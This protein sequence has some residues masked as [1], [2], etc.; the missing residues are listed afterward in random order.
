MGMESLC[1]APMTARTLAHFGS[2][3]PGSFLPFV[4]CHPLKIGS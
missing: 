4:Q 1:V 2:K 3:V